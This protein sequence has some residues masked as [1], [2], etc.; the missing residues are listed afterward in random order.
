MSRRIAITLVRCRSEEA[1][2]AQVTS[3][4]RETIEE[5]RTT[6]RR[7]SVLNIK[8]DQDQLI[9]RKEEN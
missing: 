9:A 1:D 5:C 7:R 2:F 3:E 4:Q 8:N 6:S